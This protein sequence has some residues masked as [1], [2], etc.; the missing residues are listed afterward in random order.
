[1]VQ[2]KID[3]IQRIANLVGDGRSQAAHYGSFFNLVKPC[4]QFA[5]A[6][7]PRDHLVER[8][9][10]SAH[11]IAAVWENMNAEVSVGARASRYRQIFDGPRKSPN[12]QACDES[13]AKQ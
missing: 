6:S 10:E 13:G 2:R 8:R 9:R 5:R 12:K 1:M 11:F 4:L 7:K 3:V